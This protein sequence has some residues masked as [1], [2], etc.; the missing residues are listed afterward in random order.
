MV[1]L[2]GGLAWAV[3]ER[4]WAGTACW[5][6]VGPL[7][8]GLAISSWYQTATW[9]HSLALWNHALESGQGQ[10]VDVQVA[11]GE[12]LDEKGRG[13]EALDHY[14]TAVELGPNSAYARVDLA[15]SLTRHGQSGR[16]DSGVAGILPEPAG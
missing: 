5:A 4:R 6:V 15:V 11:L 3:R 14:I 8:I 2:A 9:R 1:L 12:A 7:A 13:I 10:S 16:R